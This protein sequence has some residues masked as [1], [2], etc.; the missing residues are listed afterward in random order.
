VPNL[1]TY[2]RSFVGGE[3][4]PEFFGRLDDAKEQ[5]GLATCRNF[6]VKP[7]GP[8]ANR[9][10]TFFVSKVKNTAVRTRVI[11]F[12]AAQDQ[13]FVIEL[14]AGY[15][16]FHTEGANLL[17]PAA[18]AWSG[19]TAYTQGDLASLLGVTYYCILGHT[20]HTPPNATYWY[21]LP[22]TAYELPNP[23]TEA[24]LAQIKHVQSNDIVTF[25]HPNYPPAELERFSDTRWLYTIISFTS[26]LSPP[27]SVS[28]TATRGTTPGTASLQSYVI[29][30]VNGT[31]ESAASG[32]S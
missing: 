17:A 32:T 13:S 12:V 21:P 6:I 11:A 9:G 25:T 7:H 20:N 26:A 10:G 5:T 29:T 30:A 1:R 19:A 31:D 14:G 8:V 16:R 2:A 23:Y 4:T 15:F 18:T 24:D 27:T 22:S 28:A 3:V